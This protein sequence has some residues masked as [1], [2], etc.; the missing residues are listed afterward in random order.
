[1]LVRGDR[2]TTRHNTQ[3]E[4]DVPGVLLRRESE[5]ERKLT[6]IESVW[7]NNK[8]KKMC[9]TN[10]WGLEL[11]E[12]NAR[13]VARVPLK[14]KKKSARNQIKTTMISNMQKFKWNFLG[15]ECIANRKQKKTQQHPKRVSCTLNMD[16]LLLFRPYITIWYFLLFYFTKQL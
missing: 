15:P 9:T 4:M 12:S 13:D 6:E 5:R 11:W 2:R 14:K 10:L 16:A 8:Q 7:S 3:D 1:M